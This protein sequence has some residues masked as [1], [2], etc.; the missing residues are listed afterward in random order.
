SPLRVMGH[1]YGA[2][3]ALLAA[4]ADPQ[5][6]SHCAALAPFVSAASLYP[7]AGVRVRALIERLDGLAEIDD[8]LGPRDSRVFA[9]RSTA[10]LFV[11]HGSADAVIPITQFHALR[12]H[13]AQHRTTPGPDPILLEVDGA[14]HD[15]TD[16]DFTSHVRAGAEVSELLF[17]FLTDGLAVVAL[18]DAADHNESTAALTEKRWRLHDPGRGGPPGPAARTIRRP[19]G[20]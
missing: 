19:G 15:L 14:D 20:R 12:E 5:L 10:R 16:Y 13:L 18:P 11:A 7:E 8:E 9:A 2:Y 3:L 17:D 6:W 4:G 1:S